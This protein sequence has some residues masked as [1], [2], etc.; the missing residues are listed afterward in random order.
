[1]QQTDQAVNILRLRT[2]TTSSYLTN[3]N[4]IIIQVQGLAEHFRDSC[5]GVISW[6]STSTR[7]TA[8]IEGWGLYAENPLIA[9]DTDMYHGQP[10]YKY[11]MLRS[12]V[13]LSVL[14]RT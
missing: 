8:F 5:G 14:L 3:C 2:K 4:P 7:Y 12:Q 10:M 1:M 6:L 13:K 11:G 9:V